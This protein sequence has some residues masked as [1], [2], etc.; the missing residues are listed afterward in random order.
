MRSRMCSRKDPTFCSAVVRPR[1]KS[2]ECS[3][4]MAP[5][6]I[7]DSSRAARGS[8]R[9]ERFDPRC[10]IA[11]DDGVRDNR[12]GREGMHAADAEPK[13]IAGQQEIDGLS[14]PVGPKDEPDRKSTRLNS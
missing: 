9:G 12:L 3:R 5:T 4:D 10:W 14:T 8:E 11:R 1:I 2:R 6:T 7:P 13:E